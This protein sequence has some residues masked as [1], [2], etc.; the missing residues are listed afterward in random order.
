MIIPAPCVCAG[1]CFAFYL[2]GHAPAFPAGTKKAHSAECNVKFPK[3]KDDHGVC[4]MKCNKLT[5]GM[6][7]IDESHKK[8]FCIISTLFHQNKTTVFVK[9]A[10]NGCLA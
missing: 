4:R 10:I 5:K 9:H 2:W 1:T 8:P 7:L 6:Y 3:L